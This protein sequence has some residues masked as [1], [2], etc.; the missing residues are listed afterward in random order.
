MIASKEL[1][2]QIICSISQVELQAISETKT[3]VGRAIERDECK[4]N[5]NDKS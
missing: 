3:T 2:I 4:N 5:E 1:A